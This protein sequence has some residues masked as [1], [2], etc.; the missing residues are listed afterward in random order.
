LP[1]SYQAMSRRL[2]GLV[3]EKAELRSV[4]IAAAERRLERLRA[5]RAET[6]ET[7]SLDLDI[8]RDLKRIHSHICSVAYPVLD[9]ARTDQIS[10]ARSTTPMIEQVKPSTQSQ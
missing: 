3:A 2:N 5:G 10:F 7:T 8:L 6:L 4:E 9:A 1:S